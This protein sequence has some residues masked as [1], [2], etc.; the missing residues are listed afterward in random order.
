[1]G[2]DP[3]FCLID[4]CGHRLCN[5]SVCGVMGYRLGYGMSEPLTFIPTRAAALARMDEFLPAAGRYVA[6]RNYVR[7]GHDNVSHLSPWVQ[8]R[9][10]LESEIVAGH[11][12]GHAVP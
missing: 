7:P 9:L 1:M 8:K 12:R 6:E 5:R 4:A 10:L 11:P 2:S 3:V